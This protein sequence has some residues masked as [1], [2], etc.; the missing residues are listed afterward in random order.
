M[1]YFFDTYAFF[2]IIQN[3][4]DYARFKDEVLITTVLNLAELY[5]GLLQ[6]IGKGKTDAWFERFKPDLLEFDL[7][8]AKKAM[9]FR[10]ANIK[11]KFS[12]V[13]CISY[14]VA[15][16]HGLKFL[17]GDPAFEGLP[18]VEFVK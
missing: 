3:N 9:A 6:K 13:D 2:E 11:K 4:P 12:M 14:I 7:D 10:Y 17:T 5:Y 18:N 1:M 15:L 16:K 8:I